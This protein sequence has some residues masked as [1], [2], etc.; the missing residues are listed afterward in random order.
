M[1][2]E[3]TKDVIV[4]TIQD[5]KIN[6]IGEFENINVCVRTCNI[7]DVYIEG[8][9]QV[10]FV[11]ER[12]WIRFNNQELKPNTFVTRGPRF[13]ISFDS[14]KMDFNNNNN[15]KVIGDVKGRYELV[16]CMLDTAIDN[17]VEG[18]AEYIKFI[19][20]TVEDFITSN[21]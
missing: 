19:P 9:T 17:T 6:V 15:N 16:R 11:L 5:D 3:T 7:E 14:Y 13:N 12:G 2:E 18:I 8:E 20:Q 4:Y 21:K 1:T 10:A